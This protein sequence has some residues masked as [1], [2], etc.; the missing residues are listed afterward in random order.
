MTETKPQWEP[1][2]LERFGHLEDKLYR[3]V[4]AF[5]AIRKE[6]DT[7]RAEN[8][9]LKVEL[10]SVQE[11]E[12]AFNDNLAHLQKERE[13]LRERVEKALNLLA[14]LEVR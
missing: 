11:R 4:E 9:K 1:T 8:Q 5:K 6:N 14:T 13:E 10:Q 3:V 7:L 2:G 12:S